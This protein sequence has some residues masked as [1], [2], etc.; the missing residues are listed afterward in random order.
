M[1]TPVVDAAA[2]ARAIEAMTAALGGDAIQTD[3]AA[4]DEFRDPFW[5]RGAD[6]HDVAAAVMPKS[7]E[8]VQTVVR[9]ANEHGVPLWTVS[10]GRNYGYGG[11]APRVAGS[12]LVNLSAMNKVLEINEDLGYAVVE[13]GVRWFDLCDALEEQGGK[14]WSSIPDLGWGSVVGNSLEYGRGHTRYGS[15]G[16]NICGMEVVLPNGELMR[17]GMGAMNGNKAWHVYPF[18]YGPSVDGL[19]M[20]SGMGIVTRIGWRLMPRPEKYASCWLHFDGDEI[21]VPVIDTMRELMLDE[22][23]NNYPFL[24]RGVAANAEGQPDL[25]PTSQKWALRFALYGYEEIV[26]AKWRIVERKLGAI[27]GVQLGMK[28]YDGTD[29]VGPDQGIHDDRVQAGIPGMELLDLYK[30]PFGPDTGHLDFSPVGPL[31]G[32]EV[33]AMV[34]R[35]RGLYEQFGEPYAAGL[36][37]LPTSI[38]VVSVMFFDPKD[39]AK[40]RAIY[41]NYDPMLKALAGEGYGLYRTNIYKMDAVADTFDFNDHAMRRFLETLKDAVDPNGI[42]QAGK[43]GIWP[44]GMRDR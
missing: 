30:V 31:V 16:S 18:S 29:R 26:T 19:F 23:I 1:V 44:K 9:I 7:V 6:D 40:T 4:L 28:L 2:V 36:M 12:I 34:R 37:L 10:T 27:P 5:V 8:E 33:L 17:T 15:H 11:A 25:D 41:D 35:V 13:P 42:L 38:I 20:Q 24:G 3:R 14:W 32:T 21:I 39:E 22:T 43:Q